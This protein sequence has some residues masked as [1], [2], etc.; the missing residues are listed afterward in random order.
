MNEKL[1]LQAIKELGEHFGKK[2]K[3]VVSAIRDTPQKIIVQADK[4]NDGIKESVDTQTATLSHFASRIENAINKIKE[5]KFSGDISIETSSLENELSGIAK[6]LKKI[7]NI[8]QPDLNNVEFLLKQVTNGIKDISPEKTL[9][10]INKSLEAILNALGGIK[11]IDTFK[12]DEMQLRKLAGANKGISVDGGQMAARNVAITNL[13]LTATNTQYSYTFPA[14]TT[15]FTIK[16]RDQGTLAFYSFT[17]G[18]LPVVGGGGD[19]SK[20]ATIPQ[21]YLQSQEGVDWSGK[22]IYLGSE[23]ASQV[24]E[25]TVFTM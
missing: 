7:T 23:T 15:A 18:T 19:A 22:V 16:L 17:T 9:Q 6:D 24:A 11:P 13:A 5:P 10:E 8:K 21:N 1:F 25:I 20:Y 14:N 4:G 3:E 12:L 2:I